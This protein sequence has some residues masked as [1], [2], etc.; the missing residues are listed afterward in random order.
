[1][2][3]LMSSE[4]LTHGAI[5]GT[6]FQRSTPYLQ[7]PVFNKYV[8]KKHSSL[9]L[10]SLTSM[11]MYMRSFMTPVIPYVHFVHVGITQRQR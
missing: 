1:M 9:S 5:H 6:K 2:V 8:N 10:Q 7:H 4:E 11:H 3:S